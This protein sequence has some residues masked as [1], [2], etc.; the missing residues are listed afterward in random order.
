M[1]PG[2]EAIKGSH[3]AE[4]FCC[5]ALTLPSI[6]GCGRHHMPS[7]GNSLDSKYIRV[8]GSL[9]DH[10]MGFGLRTLAYKD[11]SVYGFMI[12]WMSTM[13]I[14]RACCCGLWRVRHCSSRLNRVR[15]T[16]LEAHRL[17]HVV[18]TPCHTRR[19]PH[20]RAGSIYGSAS[21][22]HGESIAASSHPERVE[23]LMLRPHHSEGGTPSAIR[24]VPCTSRQSVMRVCVVVQPDDRQP[25]H[26]PFIL[27]R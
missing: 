6:A 24:C 25:N 13:S 16:W 1:H 8:A 17:R 3:A 7:K 27:K 26:L 10:H 22:V 15:A 9:T 20:F 12:V 2:G 5:S 21:M 14:L 23:E 11:S 18:D 19:A 4:H